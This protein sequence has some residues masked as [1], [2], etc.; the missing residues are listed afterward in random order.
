MEQGDED[1]GDAGDAVDNAANGEEAFEGE[2]GAG[3]DLIG[4]F[5]GEAGPDEDEEG[6]G[7][8]AV[9]EPLPGVHAELTGDEGGIG[10]RVARL[11]TEDAEFAD[12][13]AGV[14]Q[15]HEADG[16]GDDEEVEEAREA[17]LP[18]LGSTL[19]DVDGT[20]GEAGTGAGVAVAAGLRK[21]FGI[22]GGLGVR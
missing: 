13:V 19:R 21:V 6:N 3:P 5:E 4:V 15:E 22:D 7:E 20:D 11:Q 17:G 14:M 10:L 12:P 16:D 1:H 2:Q 18:G 9:L 8:E